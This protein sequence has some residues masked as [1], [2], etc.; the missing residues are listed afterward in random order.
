MHPV[1]FHLLPIFLLAGMITPRVSAQTAPAVK[2]RIEPGLET[3]VLWQWTVLPSDEKA[4]GFEV[5]APEAPSEEIKPGAPGITPTISI[6]PVEA[7]PTEYLV[8]SGDALGTIS[9]K[10]GM[11]VAQLKTAN[12]LAKD[13]IRI[14][15][16]LKIPTLEEIK[17]MAPPPPPPVAEK[18]AAKVVPKAPPVPVLSREVENVLFQV[19]LDR[20]RFPTGPID[21]NPG[22]SFENALQLYRTVHDDVPGLDLLQKKALAAVGEVFIRYKLKPEDFRFIAPS[23]VEEPTTAKTPL[24]KSKTRQPMPEPPPLSYEALIAQPFLA[25]RTP[26]EFIAERFHCDE[27]FLRKQNSKITGVPTEGTDFLVPNVIPFEIENAFVAP[28]QPI[29]DPARP[30]TAAIADLSRLE[31]FEAGKLVAAMPLSSA[32]P[33]LRGRGT[34]T[35]LEALPRPRLMTKQELKAKSSASQWTTPIAEPAAAAVPASEQFLASGPN[36]PLGLL[37][38]NLAKAK[39]TTP[40]PYGLHGTSIPSRMKSQESLGGFRL[41]NWDIVRAVRLLPPGT[42]LHWK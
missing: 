12:D 15:Q 29:A 33:D 37:W 17:A 41:A 23:F 39:S 21:G 32:R 20:E 42:S 1:R 3:A 18:E 36:N 26:W 14:G 2:P 8:K 34:W 35:L 9:R 38:I 5:K 19:F 16:K 27:T 30:M 13:I 10:Y 31:V 4:W 22:I 40:L 28:L 11:T 6:K 25:Y 7:R 24:R